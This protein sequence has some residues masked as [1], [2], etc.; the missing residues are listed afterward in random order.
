MNKLK[1]LGNQL[2]QT[3]YLSYEKNNND[4]HHWL[5]FLSGSVSMATAVKLSSKSPITSPNMSAW[6]L[7]KLASGASPTKRSFCDG[8]YGRQIT[9]SGFMEDHLH[10]KVT[11]EV[12][13]GDWV[14]DRYVHTPPPTSSALLGSPLYAVSMI[15]L[16]KIV[17]LHLTGKTRKVVNWGA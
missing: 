10:A 11:P 6:A 13:E 5:T 14:N 3:A 16:T 4:F 12:G 2:S 7:L 17:L 15:Q 8:I 9:S 1:A